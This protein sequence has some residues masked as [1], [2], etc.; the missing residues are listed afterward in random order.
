MQGDRERCLAAGMTDYVAKPLSKRELSAVLLR[1]IGTGSPAVV[2]PRTP[3]AK[4]NEPVI[5]P[6]V[7]GLNRGALDQIRELDP[8]GGGALLARVGQL[9][10]ETAPALGKSL[11]EAAAGGD[12]VGVRRAAH[13]LKS[14]S[15]NLGADAL[16][17]LCSRV[18]TSAAA[19]EILAEAV[20]GIRQE[21][22]LAMLLVRSELCEAQ[23]A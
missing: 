20:E 5:V 9:Y 19:G 6:I 17:A 2:R 10:L 4:A 21:L 8:T 23:P 7:P 15:A 22:S 12:P 1:C 16:S 14:S 18:E 11:S 13:S 3:L